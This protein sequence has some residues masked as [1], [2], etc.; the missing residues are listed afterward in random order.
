MRASHNDQPSTTGRDDEPA[1]VSKVTSD[2]KFQSAAVQRLNIGILFKHGEADHAQLGVNNRYF[3]AFIRLMAF[4]LNTWLIVYT[5]IEVYNAVKMLNLVELLLYGRGYD[6][7]GMTDQCKKDANGRC[8]E[9]L[10]I[11]IAQVVIEL[12]SLSYMYLWLLFLL[13]GLMFN[14]DR[15]GRARTVLKASRAMIYISGVSTLMFSPSPMLLQTIWNYM[16]DLYLGNC[17][18]ALLKEDSH[19]GGNTAGGRTKDEVAHGSMMS[20]YPSAGL[21]GRAI[22]RRALHLMGRVSLLLLFGIVVGCSCFF[23]ICKLTSL[24]FAIKHNVFSQ[25]RVLPLITYIGALNQLAYVKDSQW[26]RGASEQLY[27]N[28]RFL[29]SAPTSGGPSGTAV[30]EARRKK[31]QEEILLFRARIVST[32]LM[33]F[34]LIRGFLLSLSL[35]VRDEAFVAHHAPIKANS[36]HSGKR[37]RLNSSLYAF[38]SYT[39]AAEREWQSRKLKCLVE[40]Q[41]AASTNFQPFWVQAMNLALMLEYERSRL[42]RIGDASF[43]LLTVCLNTGFI[44]F[45][46]YQAMKSISGLNLLVVLAFGRDEAVREAGAVPPNCEDPEMVNDQECFSYVR[47]L[48]VQVVIELL[49]IV[50]MWAQLLVTL[51]TSRSLLRIKITM[52]HISG[53]STLL[54]SPSNMLV[55]D[56]WRFVWTHLGPR[57]D[58]PSAVARLERRRSTTDLALRA[59]VHVRELA[60]RVTWSMKA[61]MAVVVFAVIFLLTA[62][63]LICKLTSLS[64]AIEGTSLGLS[65]FPILSYVAALNQLSYAMD[66]R[67]FDGAF[68]HLY[69]NFPWLSLVTRGFHNSPYATGLRAARQRRRSQIT[70][71]RRRIL[72]GLIRRHG[73]LL[74]GLLALSVTVQDEAFIAYFPAHQ[75]RPRDMPSTAPGELPF[76]GLRAAS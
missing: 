49:A 36:M 15:H 29:F 48:L 53:F 64:F 67:W 51:A 59:E 23:L 6:E 60:A 54:F 42:W 24:S 45:T 20:I 16:N 50:I 27:Q 3:L 57:G 26:N 74:G 18:R 11:L 37:P 68:E 65:L 8:F 34:G 13:V 4:G 72:E 52:L 9:H 12:G 55:Q 2:V 22:L 28:Y 17:P 5:F 30:R 32:L 21:S 25:L 40:L 61:L 71:F 58:D 43:R 75:L 56:L 47:I 33:Q 63:F 62:S 44:A 76:S 39:T 35:E 1:D 66:V 69:H 10:S 7:Q 38:G 73:R 19:I 46:F 70:T 31:K 14:H 41:D